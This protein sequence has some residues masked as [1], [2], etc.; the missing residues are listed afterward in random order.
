MSEKAAKTPEA[1]RTADQDRKPRAEEQVGPD[2]VAGTVSVAGGA[3]EPTPTGNGVAL[4]QREA[5]PAG[6]SRSRTAILRPARCLC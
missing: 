4:L 6:R 2:L 1:N 3:G 5:R